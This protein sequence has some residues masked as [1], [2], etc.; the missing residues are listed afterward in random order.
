MNPEFLPFNAQRAWLD[1]A[2]A[3]VASTR[4][5]LLECARWTDP[6]PFA[7]AVCAVVD[8]A[9]VEAL[10][11]VLGESLASADDTTLH[12]VLRKLDARERG[13]ARL[14]P[15]AA[16]LLRVAESFPIERI[17]ARC[18]VERWLRRADFPW[19][20][21]P[22][23]LLS[24][25]GAELRAFC[26]G[27]PDART[28]VDAL[29]ARVLD[30]LSR[31]PRSLSQAHAEELLAA[32]V[33]TTASH[34]L[35]ELL[36][37]ADDAEATEFTVSIE[38]AE[39]TVSH[40]G[41][42][43][44][45]RDVVGVLSVGQSTKGRG[46]IGTFGVGFKSVY[47]V[48]ARPRVYS[49]PFAFEIVD[50]SRPRPVH[51]R[52]SELAAGH[53]VIV[54]PLSA[55]ENAQ[56]GADAVLRHAR[57]LPAEVLLTLR[58]VRALTVKGARHV[59]A[60]AL[61]DGTVR[62]EEGSAARSFVVCA[63][64]DAKVIVALGE[65]GELVPVET[66]R[67]TLYAFLPT[68]ERTGLHVR[69]QAPFIVPV[70]R[71]RVDLAHPVN[72][73]LL[74]DVADALTEALVRLRGRAGWAD[75]APLPEEMAHP[76]LRAMAARV[77]DALLREPVLRAADGAWITPDRAC[78][79]ADAS[80]V[81]V[82]ADFTLTPEGHRALPDATGRERAV[83]RWFGVRTIDAGGLCAW[84]VRASE[85]I[86]PDA[87]T[88]AAVCAVLASIARE[89]TS[90]ERLR[91]ARVALDDAGG[92]ALPEVLSRGEVSLRAIYR[93]LRR[94]LED[95]LDPDVGG[96]SVLAGLWDALGV[97][98]LTPERLRADL[99]S[100]EL[101]EALLRDGGAL[102][103]LACAET[104]DARALA[105]LG[106]LR[107]IPCE[108]RA[109][110]A[111][112]GEERAWLRPP[113]ALG[114]FMA[115]EVPAWV[116]F[117][118]QEVAEAFGA[119]LARMGAVAASLDVLRVVAPVMTPA[120]LRRLYGVLAAM[121]DEL[122][123]AAWAKVVCAPWFLDRHEVARALVGDGAALW[124]T[125]DTIETLVPEAPWLHPDVHAS[126]VLAAVPAQLVPRVG[127]RDIVQ[128][129]TR[130][131]G[132]LG[133]VARG[134]DFVSA[135]MAWLGAHPEALD[136][137][138]RAALAEARVWADTEG[139]LHALASLRWP[140]EAHALTRLYEAWRVAPM[141]GET[142]R[143]IA[144]SLGL[145][146]VCARCDAETLLDDLEA[147][148]PAT[149][150][151]RALVAEAVRSLARGANE[152]WRARAGRLAMFRTED[153]S[154]VE[155]SALYREREPH[156][157]SLVR[158]LGGVL[159]GDDE[160]TLWGSALDV[161]GPFAATAALVRE[162]VKREVR[163][164]LAFTEQP[165]WV[166][167]PGALR[168]VGDVLRRE[169]ARW[170]EGLAVALNVRGELREPPLYA[171]TPEER[172]LCEGLAIEMTLA[173]AEF[174]ARAEEGVVRPLPLRR[175]TS[176]LEE[177]T[178]ASHS[179]S[180][181]PRLCDE[182][183]RARL[184]AWV[185]S[186]AHEIVADPEARAAL[187]RARWVPSRGGALRAP[188]ELL[189]DDDLPDLG[190]DWHVAEEVPQAL[191]AWLRET[192]SLEASRLTTLVGHLLEGFARASEAGDDA[193]M[194]LLLGHIARAVR[195]PEALASLPKAL[196]VHRA[197]TVAASDGTR[198]AP[199]ELVF[200]P[201]EQRVWVARMADV[202]TLSER[203]DEDETLRAFL[204]ALGMQDVV[205][206][207]RLRALLDGRGLREGN[208]ARLALARYVAVNALARPSLRSE[209]DLDRRAWVPDDARGWRRPGELL[210]PSTELDAL[211]GTAPGRRAHEAFVLAVPE[212]LSRWLPFGHASGLSLAD[213]LAGAGDGPLSVTALR[214]IERALNEGRITPAELRKGLAGR[215]VIP[216]DGGEGCAAS[217][218]F[219]D[220]E[221][222]GRFTET[223]A[224]FPRV[225]DVLRVPVRPHPPDPL[226]L[227]VE[228]EPE[229]EPSRSDSPSP[230]R[231][232]GPGGEVS[233]G[234]FDRLRGWFRGADTPVRRQPEAKAPKPRRGHGWYAPT[235]ALDAQTEEARAWL[236]DRAKESDFGFVY[237][238]RTLPAPYL[239]APKTIARRFDRATQRWTAEGYCDPAWRAPG[240][241]TGARVAFRG[242][243][244]AGAGLVLPLPLYGALSGGAGDGELETSASGELRYRAE[245]DGVLEFSVTL[246]GAPVFE[247]RD[248]SL[249]TPAELSARTCPDD[250]LPREVLAFV[251]AVLSSPEP[252]Y[253]RALDVRDFVRANYRYDPRYLEDPSVAAFLA[254]VRVGRA[255]GALAALHA[256]RTGRHLGAGVCFELNA[257]VCELLRRVGV[258]AAVCTGWVLDD[259]TATEPDHLW[260]MALL[261]TARGPRW[262]PLDASSTREGRPLR[263]PKRAAPK[264]VRAPPTPPAPPGGMPANPLW[265]GARAASRR[266]EGAHELARVPP[267]GELLRVVR[268][269]ESVTGTTPSRDES[270]RRACRELLADTARAK[271]FLAL[272]RRES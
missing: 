76:L 135:A 169:N 269:V 123:P 86:T 106:R 226:S 74:R 143:V 244:P 82:L 124:A 132:V 21:E 63:R 19:R 218:L 258:P 198:R 193:R 121:R 112:V 150:P 237:V 187:G 265:A 184:Y 28:E 272:L 24:R 16:L 137:N 37:N 167:E 153:G 204:R 270:L 234:V 145:R 239:Y 224:L 229:P 179:V 202:A 268:Y 219:L 174:A 236:D 90:A 59:R 1:A 134:A 46:Q 68:L 111:L 109:H 6:E 139:V 254:E 142:S 259:G 212:A 83:R 103:I 45:P 182:M 36:Q 262:M 66:G 176:A 89:R 50:V 223:A 267:Q 238:P 53:T 155:A 164:G 5:A 58:H 100:D 18:L 171:V 168:A 3:E 195:T 138:D 159:L 8:A 264:G 49:G 205:P 23:S 216:D 156:V 144:E 250:E 34:F 228:G 189:L 104:W 85:T 114:D 200:V 44:A 170:W 40:D 110:R 31:S 260:A 266:G 102:R 140:P 41:S 232:R 249:A 133:H 78:V 91:G 255:H 191:R 217:E 158:S 60:I 4:A 93:G 151:S 7:L 136:V 42:P 13:R 247:P 127:A 152:A 157:R 253:V 25:T 98:R 146:D 208:E 172:A 147:S 62:L 125:S 9:R 240:V 69:V 12:R 99:A 186:R 126:G 81:G 108:D 73:M 48:S 245:R 77:G 10:S 35:E 261:P 210:W 38:G 225:A 128:A 227:R 263:V 43:F 113:G 160:E 2:L 120:T 181:H 119:T 190:V 20:S 199:R 175:V 185:L 122:S 252:A 257:L 56:R 213:V 163:H 33:Y 72:G 27:D 148:D 178:R 256:G 117:V 192:Y 271:E 222:R 206:V 79:L 196:K 129:L 115:A 209:L 177:D 47:A 243:V 94:M 75:V 87:K 116:P 188:V 54:L 107:V 211:L 95:A 118:R 235:D 30:T 149:W 26:E 97:Q 194:E 39:V 230:D 29:G 203:H 197:V 173:D 183:R 14:A 52:P 207:E 162:R 233:P 201:K 84:L 166:R 231:E 214:W 246:G 180:E 154:L 11:D 161:L 242:V 130:N 57:A 80:L 67:P 17:E 65:R 71:E 220:G 32:S 96:A 22:L 88:L 221:G 101:R 141:P 241:A 15:F 70:D 165:A 61:E 55:P 51:D 92:F 131:G 248:E 105:A 215:R 64:G 251:D